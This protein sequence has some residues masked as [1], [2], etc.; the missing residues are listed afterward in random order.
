MGSLL[1]DRR[2]TMLLSSRE[3]FST[4]LAFDP[5]KPVFQ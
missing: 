4:G 1:A 5:T 3:Q 2:R